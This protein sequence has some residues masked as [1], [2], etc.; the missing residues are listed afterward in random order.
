MAKILVVDDDSA[1]RLLYV[2]LLSPFGHEVT[3]ARDGQQA[4]ETAC[5]FA[6]ALVISDILMPTMNGYEFVSRLRQL[7]T[8][9]NV[10]VI[11]QSASFLD[12][13]TKA[14]GQA[15]GVKEFISKPCEPEEI[16]GTVNR[17]LGIPLQAPISGLTYQGLN[18][19]VPMLIDAFY[20]KGKQLDAL[21]VRLAA[22]LDLGL[23]LSR[24]SDPQRLLEHAVSA[25][26]KIIGANYAGAGTVNNGDP[27]LRFFATSG[28]DEAV[29]SKLS[30]PALAGAFREIAVDG[31]TIEQ[32]SQDQEISRLVLPDNNH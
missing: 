3:E 19:P 10:P 12:H 6:P 26:R 13:E 11:F 8:F 31:A 5:K 21:S 30:R 9:E 24:S 14:L 27:L 28:I 23:D 20:K 1:S 16:L 32:F 15:C 17:V 25:A 22:L 29:A 7:P 4:L 18:D 2:S